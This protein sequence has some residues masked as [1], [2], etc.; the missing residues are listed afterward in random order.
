MSLRILGWGDTMADAEAMAAENAY[1]LALIEDAVAYG[2]S[3]AISRALENAKTDGCAKAAIYEATYRGR[4]RRQARNE[5][6]LEEAFE[7]DPRRSHFE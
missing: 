2:S 4:K 3:V 7:R 5:R 1:P 6:I